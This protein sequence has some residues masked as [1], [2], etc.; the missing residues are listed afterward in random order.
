MKE[1]FSLNIPALTAHEKKIECS[2]KNKKIM[3]DYKNYL[4]SFRR[5]LLVTF[6]YKI[7]Q[8]INA[9]ISTSKI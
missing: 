9:H 3:I 1:L 6:L 4:Y 5:F 7:V 8:N 2:A